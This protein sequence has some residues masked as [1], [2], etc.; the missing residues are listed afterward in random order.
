MKSITLRSV[1]VTRLRTDP[2]SGCVGNVLQDARLLCKSCPAL[3]KHGLGL[4]IYESIYL[5][6]D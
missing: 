4:S 3:T 6:M 2:G 5:S 1:F